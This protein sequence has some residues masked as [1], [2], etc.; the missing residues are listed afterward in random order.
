M[1][2]GDAAAAAGHHH[3]PQQQQ[4][5][6]LAWGCFFLLGSGILA[7]WN[8]VIT[9]ADLYEQLFPVR[10]VR[11]VLPACLAGC[12]ACCCL[13]VLLAHLLPNTHTHTPPKKQTPP[14]PQ[15]HHRR[16]ATWIASSQSPTCQPACC[17]WQSQSTGQP[18][19]PAPASSAPTAS[20][21]SS[22]VHSLW[23]VGRAPKRFTLPA[24]RPPLEVVAQCGS[25]MRLV[26]LPD[27]HSGHKCL[28]D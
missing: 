24:A 3:R 15:H 10:V 4:H 20:S 5:A 25:A 18:S 17:S 28:T 1:S 23:W 14:T 12:P 13:I 19:R 21:R 8:A 6:R 7:P 22:C 9:A 26:R 11:G 2:G 16:A 27:A